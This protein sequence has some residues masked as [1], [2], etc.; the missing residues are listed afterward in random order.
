MAYLFGPYTPTTGQLIEVDIP[1]DSAEVEVQNAS[2]YELWA[3]FSPQVPLV[4]VAL[5]TGN[6]GNV[7][8]GRSSKILSIPDQDPNV[9]FSGR[10]WLY[11]YN[12]FSPRAVG[13]SGASTI[14]VI[15]SPTAGELK[16]DSGIAS[17][18]VGYVPD[19]GVQAFVPLAATG[20]QV[21]AGGN[22]YAYL[23]T[24][25]ATDPTSQLVGSAWSAGAAFGMTLGTAAAP[26]TGKRL[27]LT[28]ALLFP[29][30]A[31]ANQLVTILINNL[32]GIS[33]AAL[34]ID[35]F[36]TGSMAPGVPVSFPGGIPN[37][38]TN[39]SITLTINFNDPSTLAAQTANAGGQAYILLSTRTG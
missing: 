17:Q 14:Y 37:A 32:A 13:T 2:P 12:P 5:G 4:G 27:Y 38:F 8:R 19:A 20:Y 18:N 31:G 9:S 7:V 6:Y 34:Q 39:V 1:A 3:S 21:D 28:A 35:S 11:P 36:V 33:P 30:P 10:L 16:A 15:T 24:A 22:P 26:G 25:S 23:A 29:Y